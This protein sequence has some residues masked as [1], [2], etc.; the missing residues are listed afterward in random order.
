[1]TARELH[2]IIQPMF[3]GKRVAVGVS[4]SEDG[5]YYH[6][7]VYNYTDDVIDWASR[8]VGIIDQAYSPEELIENC[9][10]AAEG[11]VHSETAETEGV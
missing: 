7:S 2:N 3:P 11:E 8:P 5:N 9:K 10:K 6:C 1:M 4:A